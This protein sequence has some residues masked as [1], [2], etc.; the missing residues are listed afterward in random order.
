MIA[1][2]IDISKSKSTVAV[3]DSNGTV[4]TSPFTMAHTQPEMNAF[5]AYLKML[6]EP[7]TILMEYTGHYHYPVLKKLQSFLR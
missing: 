7:P 5:V 4:L 1:V 2:W 3:I 6:G